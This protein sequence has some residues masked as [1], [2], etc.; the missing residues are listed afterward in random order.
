MRNDKKQHINKHTFPN[1]IAEIIKPK[2]GM[3]PVFDSDSKPLMQRLKEARELIESS[4][5]TKEERMILEETGEVIE[6]TAENELKDIRDGALFDLEK[7]K[8]LYD[9]LE[10]CKDEKRKC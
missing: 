10:A 2:P 8:S 9:L 3:G 6:E 4:N 5:L 1:D 7:G